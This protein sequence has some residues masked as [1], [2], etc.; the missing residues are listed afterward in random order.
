MIKAEA[1][2]DVKVAEADV[3]VAKAEALVNEYKLRLESSDKERLQVNGLMT[4]RG[5]LE[6]LIIEVAKELKALNAKNPPSNTDVCEIVAVEVGKKEKLSG[7][8]SLVALYIT[9]DKGRLIYR[10]VSI[11][12]HGY[13]WSGPGVKVYTSKMSDESKLKCVIKAVAK[14]HRLEVTEVT[15]SYK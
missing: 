15:E 9:G 11:A 10:E 6:W 8:S 7:D 5:I 2:A 14:Y 3:K 13:P 1:E 4:S 12:I